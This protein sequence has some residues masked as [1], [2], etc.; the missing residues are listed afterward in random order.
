MTVTLSLRCPS[1]W[2]YSKPLGGLPK[3]G[4]TCQ[5]RLSRHQEFDP[6]Q[7]LAD[8]D[9]VQ[10]N[11]LLHDASSGSVTDVPSAGKALKADSTL[12]ICTETT[13]NWEEE[14]FSSLSASTSKNST[15][16]DSDEDI[17]EVNAALK[18]PKVKSLKEAM[19]ILEDVTEYLTSENLT[20]TAN[21]LSKVL[22]N[23]QSIRLSRKLKASVQSKVT[24]FF[25]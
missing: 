19:V 12:P 7:E 15:H 6:F 24:D 1:L 21:G 11:S 4:K 23:I 9:L 17:I 22:S 13:A 8:S 10:V 3:P 18:E 25:K 5:N 14:F 20:E 16:E 2:T